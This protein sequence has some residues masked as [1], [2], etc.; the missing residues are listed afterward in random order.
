MDGWMDN[1]RVDT[2]ALMDASMALSTQP[3]PERVSFVEVP[4]KAEA[5]INV[6]MLIHLKTWLFLAILFGT[7]RQADA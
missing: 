4:G 6:Y 1:W 2:H 3:G 5:F 7:C